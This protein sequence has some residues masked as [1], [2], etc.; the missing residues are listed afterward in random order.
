MCRAVLTHILSDI[1]DEQLIEKLER[2]YVR[3]IDCDLAGVYDSLKIIQG[4]LE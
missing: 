4:I 2:K 3:E 1:L